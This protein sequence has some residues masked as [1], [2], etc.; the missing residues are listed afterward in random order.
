MKS[1]YIRSS[2]GVELGPF[3]EEV[4]QSMLNAGVLTQGS[5]LIIKEEQEE[6]PTKS[7]IDPVVEKL[8]QSI[9]NGDLNEFL[10]LVNEGADIY[11]LDTEGHS[12][13][14]HALRVR[15]KTVLESLE[16]LEAINGR[17]IKEGEGQEEA[18]AHAPASSPNSFP[19]TD[20]QFDD[21]IVTIRKKA[22]TTDEE[23]GAKQALIELLKKKDTHVQGD[24]GETFLLLACKA[25]FWD[26]VEVFL[27]PDTDIDAKDNEGCTA[28]M[29]AA[30]SGQEKTM[31][32]LLKNGAYIND[33]SDCGV[34]ALMW[35]ASEGHKEVVE[36]LLEAGAKLHHS[37]DDTWVADLIE[38]AKAGQKEKAKLLVDRLGGWRKRG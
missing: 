24:K 3:T 28:L 10:R 30:L 19:V 37:Y 29:Y 11:A 5:Q 25:K 1:Y 32:L 21:L 23:Q 16:M 38:A 6:L 8:V 13:R 7:E 18:P 26:L 27:L 33:K 17:T 20:K 14:W 9:E 34:T 31:E 4:A 35:A 12:L 22:V 36:F 15:N 2:E